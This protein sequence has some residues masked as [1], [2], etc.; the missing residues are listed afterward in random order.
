M[1][2]RF[3]ILCRGKKKPSGI[4]AGTGLAASEAA[5]KM[6]GRGLSA[7]HDCRWSSRPQCPVECRLNVRDA[8]TSE[9]VEL[10]ALACGCAGEEPKTAVEISRQ[11]A[12]Q[13]WVDAA[14]PQECAKPTRNLG[15]PQLQLI[16]TGSPTP[17]QTQTIL[18]RWSW[19]R[20]MQIINVFI[21][22]TCPVKNTDMYTL[23]NTSNKGSFYIYRLH[24]S[25]LVGAV[26]YICHSFWLS[27][28]N[29]RK[30]ECCLCL[31]LFPDILSTPRTSWIYF[32]LLIYELWLWIITCNI[33]QKQRF[34]ML[35]HLC[36]LP[37][38]AR[39]EWVH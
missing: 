21:A 31:Y 13:V 22:K 11:L 17:S 39:K 26:F 14:G 32:M 35:V 8:T 25:P 28:N 6:N 5:S 9:P 16:K 12:L 24:L 33:V 19:R 4:T 3:F 20:E 27:C 23:H 30:G 34:K 2:L 38:A 1:P 10:A 15:L 7:G 18:H 37:T 36:H 29:V